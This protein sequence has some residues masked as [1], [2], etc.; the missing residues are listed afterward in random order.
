[1]YETFAKLCFA[2]TCWCDF[3]T[4][5]DNFPSGPSLFCEFF[6]VLIG[7]GV[8]SELVSSMFPVVMI[9]GQL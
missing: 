7:V 4:S 3:Y 5:F 2:S 6:A 8:F 9:C 1:M